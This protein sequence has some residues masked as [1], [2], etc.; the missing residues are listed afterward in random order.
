MRGDVVHVDTHSFAGT[1]TRTFACPVTWTSAC[2]ERV[3]KHSGGG[4]GSR[5]KH[6]VWRGHSSSCAG[7][8]DAT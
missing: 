2:A 4:D 7:E 5:G 1:H 6:R 3:A 8:H